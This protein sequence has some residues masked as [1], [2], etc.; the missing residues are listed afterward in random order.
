VGSDFTQS[1]ISGLVSLKSRLRGCEFSESVVTQ[2]I[3][4]ETS[5]AGS[6]FSETQITMSQFLACDFKLTEWF[7]PALERTVFVN[8]GMQLMSVEEGVFVRCQIAGDTFATGS[9]FT[10]S[11]FS[12]SGLRSLTATGI[13]FSEVRLIRTDLAMSQFRSGNFTEACFSECIANESNFSSCDFQ[14]ALISSTNL[15]GSLLIDS[16]FEGADFYESDILL[17]DF[18]NA[19]IDQAINMMPLKK[20]RLDDERRRVA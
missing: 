5:L 8:S 14:N 9:N 19:E 18:T 11:E 15:T 7:R 12:D 2:S 6:S 13:S 17:A 10:R 1:K 16:N 4:T 3:F 20:E